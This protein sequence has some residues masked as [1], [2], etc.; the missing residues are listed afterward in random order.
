MGHRRYDGVYAPS[1]T[2][3]H[4][5]EIDFR[6]WGLHLENLIAAGLDGVL[7]FGSIGEFFK[8][9]SRERMRAAEWAV[10]RV[11]GRAQLMV[12]I[13]DTDPRESIALGRHAMAAGADA[14]VL[15]S[16]YYFGPSDARA[17]AWFN[18]AASEISG[19]ILLYNFP[20]RTGSDL[21]PDLVAR[22]A[23][24]HPNIVGVKDTVDNISHT[25]GILDA[26]RD[27]RPGF[28]VFSGFDE[29]YLP[30]RL[31][32]G[33]GT[34]S[35][36]ANIR[37]RLFSSMNRAF[38]EGRN[39][40]CLEAARSIERLMPLYAIGDLFVGTIKAGIALTGLDCD[41]ADGEAVPM[42][43]DDALRLQHV[44]DR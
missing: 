35:G 24:D 20:E 14:A 44:L 21:G 32:G 2:F 17:L 4:H 25:R 12:G 33:A 42:T 8:F 19:D 29:Y 16:P 11:A 26:V 40:D 30:N 1:V 13:G 31:C 15:L 10:D 39:D 3:T 37:P 6:A 43:E 23:D 22:L 36:L 9:S 34:I 5:G 28:S 18:A 27:S 41:P 7:I 38:L